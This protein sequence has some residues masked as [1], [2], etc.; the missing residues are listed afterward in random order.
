MLFVLLFLLLV[1]CGQE[2]IVLPDESCALS[3]QA[4]IQSS[5][6]YSWGNYWLVFD[7]NHESCDVV[8]L[9]TAD[10][11]LNG[12]KFLEVTPCQNCLRVSNIHNE[13]DSVLNIDVTI[14]HPFELNLEYSCFDTRGIIIFDGSFNPVAGEFLEQYPELFP[15]YISWALLGDWEL[16]NPD[17]YTYYW[18]PPFNPDSEWPITQYMPGRFSNGTPTANINAYRDF[19][20]HEERH[21]FRAGAQVTRTYR[22]QTQPGPMVVGYSIDTCW[23]PPTKIPVGNPLLD[24]PP[25]ANAPEPYLFDIII[26]NGEPIVDPGQFDDIDTVAMIIK[27]WNGLTVETLAGEMEFEIPI[28]FPYD[29]DDRDERWYITGK[30]EE[31]RN[32]PEDMYK[33]LWLSLNCTK[34]Y[35]PAPEGWYRVFIAVYYGSSFTGGWHDFAVDITD[36]YYDPG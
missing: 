20:T 26:N 5:N 25:S 33:G 21:L 11:H 16:I 34:P 2:Q 9:R 19:Y 7:E 30:V 28:Q 6:R 22:I 27:Q 31:C 35:E 15:L 18:S 12:L 23:A 13:G 1:G 32:C 4:Q 3:T 29:G 8:P 10:F 36:F 17:G 14:Q 24:F